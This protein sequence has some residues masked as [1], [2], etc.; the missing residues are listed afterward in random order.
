M[1]RTAFA[2]VLCLGAC[3]S[4]SEG[5]VD[6]LSEYPD[7]GC[8][9]DAPDLDAPPPVPLYTELWYSVESS[10]VRI[11]LDA[12]T[13]DVVEFVQSPITGVTLPPGQS[14]LTMLRDGSIL[15]GRQDQALDQ[16]TLFHIASPPR[17]GT[18]DAV[19]TDLG[20]MPDGI[21]LEGLY[22]DCDGRVYGMD[23]GVD[24]GSADGNRLLRFTGDP[25]A[26][27]F[28]YAVV[29]DLSSAVVADIDDMSPGIE[30]NE[31]HDNPGLAIDTSHVYEFNFETGT[32]T[33]AGTGGTWG[34]HA[35]GK[36]LFTD[37]LARLYV[38]SSDAKLY[39][40]D[41]ATYEV[42]PELGTGPAVAGDNAGWSGLAGPLT[43]C[44]SGF[45]IF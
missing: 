16:T 14:M 41:P 18:S 23:T 43:E 8:D 15:G 31:I 3:G 7:C 29:S 4:K 38:L 27:D 21:N 10:L 32:G 34:I 6:S 30:N 24:V 33:E 11:K 22:T 26:H 25:V 35:L 2:L 5:P 45:V 40:M 44:D 9:T 37:H 28:T 1:R 12:A 17:D 39:R 19:A 36:E 20:V 13:G 42:S